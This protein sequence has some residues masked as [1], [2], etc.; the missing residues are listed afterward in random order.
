MCGERVTAW[1]PGVCVG[2]REGEGRRGRGRSL[3]EKKT[4]NPSTLLSLAHSQFLSWHLS[5]PPTLTPSNPVRPCMTDL[6]LQPNL[7]LGTGCGERE[8]EERGWARVASSFP[9]LPPPAR[10]WRGAVPR[11]SPRAAL[12]RTQ[13]LPRPYVCAARP[14][15]S[16]QRG[17]VGARGALPGQNALSPRAPSMPLSRLFPSNPPLPFHSFR[18]LQGRRHRGRKGRRR[19]DRGLLCPHPRPAT[20]RPQVADHDSGEN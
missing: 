9:A 1:V 19:R 17:W 10:R 7:G 14:L 12:P 5:T 16:A 15:A 3:R 18:R 6:D 2:L 11:L 8:R 13:P 20:Q 4:V